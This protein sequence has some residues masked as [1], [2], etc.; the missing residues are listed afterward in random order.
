MRFEARSFPPPLAGGRIA[1][2][3][4][5]LFATILFFVR[6]PRTVRGVIPRET[7]FHL[8]IVLFSF[9][10]GI[11]ARRS[12]HLSFLPPF[13]RK[14]FFFR[15]SVA[16]AGRHG[17]PHGTRPLPSSAPDVGDPSFFLER[18]DVKASAPPTHT[19]PGEDKNF[20]PAAARGSFQ[21]C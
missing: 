11:L 14:S 19:I 17:R 3:T 15:A 9:R 18:R 12:I 20:P 21:Q 2:G 13:P 16:L 10:S 5:P 7:H 8:A 4:P 6:A 1:R